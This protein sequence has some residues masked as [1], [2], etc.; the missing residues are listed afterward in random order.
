M[1]QYREECPILKGFYIIGYIL[2]AI[3]VITAIALIIYK[4]QNNFPI[5]SIVSGTLTLSLSA[6]AIF[7]ATY[8]LQHSAKNSEEKEDDD[9]D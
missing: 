9:N 2:S 6:I 8:A 7:V 5:Y 1:S 4:V 3:I